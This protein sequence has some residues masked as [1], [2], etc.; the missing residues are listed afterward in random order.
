MNHA[1][2][3]CSFNFV[4]LLPFAR[5]PFLI[6]RQLVAEWRCFVCTGRD[7]ICWSV[8]FAFLHVLSL[9]LNVCGGTSSGSGATGNRTQVQMCMR[10]LIPNIVA[11][12]FLAVAIARSPFLSSLLHQGLLRAEH[13]STLYSYSFSFSSVISLYPCFFLLFLT[14]FLSLYLSS[15]LSSLWH[16]HFVN[17][18]PTPI[19]SLSFFL[20]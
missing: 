8:V 1:A 14:L 5:G 20:S 6:K 15:P 10:G 4:S 3:A 9:Y 18:S 17:F 7:T 2:L 16:F 11:T 13:L 12:S 19:P